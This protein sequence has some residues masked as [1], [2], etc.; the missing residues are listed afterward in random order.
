MFTGLNFCFIHIDDI[1][2]ASV[3]E[4][5]HKKHLY[6]IFQRLHKYI[7]T[8]NLQKSIFGEKTVKFLGHSVSEEGTLPDK[9]RITAI[10]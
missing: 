7:L 2:I 1:L 8:I 3:D 4:E 9:E 5:E 10:Q 6:L